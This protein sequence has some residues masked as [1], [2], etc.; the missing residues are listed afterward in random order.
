MKLN[1]G[2]S[3]AIFYSLFALTMVGFVIK[4]KSID[5]DLVVDDYYAKDLAYQQQYDKLTNSKALANDLTINSLKEGIQLLFPKEIQQ[6]S[7]EILFYRADDKRKDFSVK[8]ATDANGM[9]LVPTSQLTP[10]R[11]TVKVDWQAGDKPFYTEKI[12]LL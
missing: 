8:I 3:I 4:S 9:Q 7:G 12:V 6:P 1:W 11:W 2:T 5:H 10:G